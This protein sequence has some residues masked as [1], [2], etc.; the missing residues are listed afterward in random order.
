MSQKCY[1]ERENEYRNEKENE[2]MNECIWKRDRMNKWMVE[3]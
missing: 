1:G 3:R 2:G